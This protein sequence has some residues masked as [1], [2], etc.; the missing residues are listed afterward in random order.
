MSASVDAV[1]PVHNAP[2]LVRRGIESVLAH[3]GQRLGVLVAVDDASEPPTVELLK[4][5]SH[6]KLRVVRSDRNL[7][8]GGAV[9]LGVAS[10]SAPL[11]L[12]LNSDV[13]ARDDFLSP[14]IRAL[15]EDPHLAGVNPG[16]NTYQR[17]DLDRYARRGR[18]IASNHLGGQAFLVRRS[19][20]TE[21]RG[22]DAVFERGYY[23]DSDFTRRV[24]RAG[25]WVG[26]HPDTSLFHQSH[27]SFSSRSEREALLERNRA[28][29]FERW[30]EARANV[31][32][33]S[34][35]SRP[36]DLP[37][38][39]VAKAQSLLDAG[40]KIWWLAADDPREMLGLG[41]RGDR[42]GL[43]R[44]V[45]RIHRQRRRAAWRHVTA[46]WLVADAPRLPAALL[47]RAARR[48]GIESTIHPCA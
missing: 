4:S 19:V 38:E 45:H 40:G 27:G 15:D 2:E 11:V 5:L 1:V 33:A 48:A 30:P 42:L 29:Y 26:V 39:L 41:M 25:H 28:H 3:V 34:R 43:R 17:Y 35:G 20:F 23:E 14:L 32:L 12:Q 9:N 44:G 47:L 46:L 18:C 16:G 8:Y 31:V 36:A 13:L 22:F 37:A 10:C 21:L 7:G 24:I 6:P